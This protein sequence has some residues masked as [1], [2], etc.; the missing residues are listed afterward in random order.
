MVINYEVY[1]NSEVKCLDICLDILQGESNITTLKF[2][3]PSTIRGYAIA[4]YMQ[5]IKFENERGEIVRLAMQNGE[6][7]LISEITRNKSVLVQLVLTNSI[8]EA[9]PI[10]WRTIPFALEFTKSINAVETI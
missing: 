1:E 3:L 5:E 2:A 10:E 6:F 7:A 4:N 8:D 9:K